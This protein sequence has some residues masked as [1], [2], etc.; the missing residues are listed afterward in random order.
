MVNT[1]PERNV[2]AVRDLYSETGGLECVWSG[3]VLSGD[4]DVDHAIPFSLRHDNSL[5][6]LF[7]A[8]SK[9]NNRKRDKLPT[10]DLVEKSRDR[11]MY[12]WEMLNDHLHEIFISDF[13]RFTGRPALPSD[14]KNPLYWSFFEAVETTAARRGVERW[15][16]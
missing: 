1:A 7:P 5:W 15:E 4:F 2:G 12:Y 14:W 11:L 13:R 6:N 10:L 9:I 8:D 3:K 16:P